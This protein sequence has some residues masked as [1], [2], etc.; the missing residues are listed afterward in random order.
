V[1][2]DKLQLAVPAVV[3]SCAAL[4]FPCPAPASEAS[5]WPPT[6]EAI[7]QHFKGRLLRF[8]PETF[9]VELL[10]DFSDESQA[11]DWFLG[12][13]IACED[14]E[15]D[16]VV[17]VCDGALHV[18]NTGAQ[19]VLLRGVFTTVSVQADF[20]TATEEGTVALLV[21]SDTKGSSFVVWRGEGAE[22]ISI[23]VNGEMTGSLVSRNYPPVSGP[24]SRGS[25]SLGFKEVRSRRG[26]REG[27]YDKMSRLRGKLGDRVFTVGHAGK[28]TL[29]S[30]H[31]GLDVLGGHAVFDNLRVTGVLDSTWLRDKLARAAE[32][33]RAAA[34]ETAR[35]RLDGILDQFCRLTRQGKLAEAG[36]LVKASASGPDSA[37]F[38]DQLGVAAYV[39]TWLEG[40]ELKIRR[41]AEMLVG[42]QIELGTKKGTLK[43]RAEDVTKEGIVLTSD[44]V[45]R[46]RV[47]GTTVLTVPWADL[48]AR[49]ESRLLAGW[50][51]EGVEG[52]I[53]NALVGLRHGD[54]AATRQAL[55]RAGDHPLAEYVR[56]TLPESKKDALPDKA[57]AA[58]DTGGEERDLRRGEG[59]LRVETT[60]PGAAVYVGRER[61]G[62]APV[63]L[64]VKAGVVGVSA[65]AKRHDPCVKTVTVPPGET[66]A[67]HLELLPSPVAIEVR[68]NASG[69]VL[70]DG[71]PAGSTNCAI[72]ARP[73]LRELAVAAEGCVDGV[74]TVEVPS[75]GGTRYSIQ[76]RNGPSFRTGLIPFD[77]QKWFIERDKGWRLVDGL[78]VLDGAGVTGSYAYLRT[79]RRRRPVDIFAVQF[80]FCVSNVQSLSLTGPGLS[81]YL[82]ESTQAEWFDGKWHVALVQVNVRA[83]TT[84][85]DGNAVAKSAGT[86]S[87]RPGWIRFRA[88]LH[89]NNDPA[90]VQLRG[91]VFKGFD[92]PQE[93]AQALGTKPLR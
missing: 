2:R 58:A 62:E 27:D 6:P 26:P 69:Q 90:K 67:V 52:E 85:I 73:G 14:A 34:E 1:K 25:M 9:E 76:L 64:V 16:A 48:T 41:A 54:A 3:M 89:E 84:T 56:R 7:G 88:M 13:G 78:A 65:R 4:A 39:V 31:I 35:R 71:V 55:D 79:R 60:P 49:E 40:R 53:A 19:C 37:S 38:S 22:H 8:D 63:S 70:V 11:Q 10:Y 74:R 44:I 72:A 21:C 93:M 91:F 43:G 75:S 17:E 42:Q 68:C 83:S 30:G 77:K 33:R 45:Q 29:N 82:I 57:P 92:S 24:E 86:A 36:A 59:L 66:V 81:L 47:I 23:C 32:T 15:G 18:A 20:E 12:K 61:V 5:F 80:G 50:K 51:M 46:G 87:P 28:P